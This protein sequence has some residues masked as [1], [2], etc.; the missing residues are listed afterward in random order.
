M[1]KQGAAAFVAT[2]ALALALAGCGGGDDAPEVTPAATQAAAEASPAATA[3]PTEAAPSTGTREAPLA[4]GES[5]Q[6]GSDSA[7]TVSLVSSNLD[8]AAAIQAADPYGPQPA[9]GE[10]FV[11]GTFS[12]T[13]SG[14]Q[15]AAQGSDL[16]N[17]GADPGQSL[18]VTYVAADGT[19]YDGASGSMCYTQNMLY[20]QGAVFQDGA[21]VTG[22]QCV[23]VP[24][25][26][27]PGGLWRVSN[28]VNDSV[29]FSAS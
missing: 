2:G 17:E 24:V 22:D 4:P 29:W 8:A 11:V 26:K 10:A 23:A 18:T 27:V 7:W 16:A 15:I 1:N 9:D 28:I 20:S 19:S 25:D 13:V 14:D 3:D 12:V 21:V 6:V 5:R